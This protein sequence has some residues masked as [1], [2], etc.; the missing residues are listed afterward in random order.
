MVITNTSIDT[1]IHIGNKLSKLQ[2]KESMGTFA[3]LKPR[4]MIVG[5]TCYPN[6]IPYIL[7]QTLIMNLSLKNTS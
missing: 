7:L 6:Y 4:D 2:I 3:V 5:V 1:V